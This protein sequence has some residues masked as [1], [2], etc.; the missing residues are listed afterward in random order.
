MFCNTKFACFVT[1]EIFEKLLE[2]Y[3]DKLLFK[4]EYCPT[5]LS[6]LVEINFKNQMKKIL[7][8]FMGILMNSQRI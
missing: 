2:G 3:C 7:K 5:F 8:T 1:N 6:S 4:F